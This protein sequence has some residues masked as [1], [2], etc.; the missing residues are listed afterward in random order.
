MNLN[1]PSGHIACWDEHVND[2][3]C[4]GQKATATGLVSNDEYLYNRLGFPRFNSVGLQVYNPN[5]PINEQLQ[6]TLPQSST[7]SSTTIGPN[8]NPV[9]PQTETSSNGNQVVVPPS[10]DKMTGFG[11]RFADFSAGALIG[12]GMSGDLIYVNGHI[13]L[14]GTGYGT[15]GLLLGGK[16]Y[17]GL[18]LIYNSSSYTDLQGLSSGF[19]GAIVS[20]GGGAVSWS[21]SVNPGANGNYAQMWTFGLATG[22]QF[23]ANY[24][25]GYSVVVPL[26]K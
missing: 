20:G 8:P 4:K 23:A 10:L 16:Y 25:V 3:G 13:V 14:M 12:G 18:D 9:T 11:V 17:G 5:L 24:S 1:D 26:T 19:Q 6:S 15:G 7:K 2:Q 21:R 22:F